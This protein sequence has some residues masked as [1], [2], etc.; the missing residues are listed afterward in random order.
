[1]EA[2]IIHNVQIA[3]VDNEPHE[4]DFIRN[5]M[6]YCVNRRVLTFATTGEMTAFLEEGHHIHL[7]LAK[8][9]PSDPDEFDSLKAVKQKFPKTCLIATSGNSDDHDRAEKLGADAFL[10][11]PFALR[12]LFKIVQDY[13][14]NN[15]YNPKEPVGLCN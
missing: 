5:V 10:A 3:V 6:T 7:L 2:A 1:M 9:P 11:K 13:V 8:I 12:D 14:V 15:T 4:R